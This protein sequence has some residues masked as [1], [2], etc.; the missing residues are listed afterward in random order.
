MMDDY[1]K[2]YQR[3][4][5]M[6]IG[7]DILLTGICFICANVP[8]L[9][10]VPF[11]SGTKIYLGLLL[12]GTAIFGTA[13]SALYSNLNKLIE[14]K[15][16]NYFKAYWHAIRMN[17]KQASFFS[18]IGG[19]VLV[20][21][22]GLLRYS[23]LPQFFKLSIIA[24]VLGWLLLLFSLISLFSFRLIDY[25]KITSYLMLVNFPRFIGVV[26]L[27]FMALIGLFLVTSFFKWLLLLVPLFIGVVWL[28]QKN[29]KEVKKIFIK[30][31]KK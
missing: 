8:L 26:G 12:P 18:I 9:L 1:N 13:C 20:S 3:Y 2:Y 24:L 19:L 7:G 5:F 6:K 11:I 10:L 17:V 29:I 27:T 30:E 4:S 22:I 21:I 15:Q 14:K 31:R 23:M 16:G 25:P 28:N